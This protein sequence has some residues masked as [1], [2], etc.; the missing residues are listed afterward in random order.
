MKKQ[1]N[2]GGHGSVGIDGSKIVGLRKR[3][4]LTQAGLAEAA[5][6]YVQ[7]VRKAEQQDVIGP[8]SLA[9]LAE[10]LGVAPS[11]LVLELKSLPSPPPATRSTADSIPRL[12][13]IDLQNWTRVASTSEVLHE[14]LHDLSERRAPALDF[15]S[16]KT[17]FSG[18]P[19]SDSYA[20]D[21]S[22]PSAPWLLKMDAKMRWVSE[23]IRAA[24]REI[25]GIGYSFVVWKERVEKELEAYF[26]RGGRLRLL[27]LHPY[28][29]GFLEKTALESY[30]AGRRDLEQW[31]VAVDRTRT[32]HRADIESSLA[33][34]DAWRA[35]VG[36]EKVQCRLYLDTPMLYGFRFDG[37]ALYASSYF[38]D[39][40]ARG[41]DVPGVGLRPADGALYQILDANFAQ[42]FEVKFATGVDPFSAT[43]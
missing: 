15:E 26:A 33:W 13:A 19:P 10:A 30:P 8:T 20:G 9:K 23:G 21:V 28:S 39:P 11:E 12:E 2:K 35:R 7:T 14:C 4:G 1:G 3:L 22:D 41:F 18:R 34:L 25:C 36:P 40:I 16:L 27:M 42:W 38:V 17:A 43:P 29:S 24:S 5:Q 37:A 6:L 32:K 31:R